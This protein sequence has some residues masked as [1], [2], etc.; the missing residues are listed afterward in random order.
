LLFRPSMFELVFRVLALTPAT[1]IDA[2]ARWFKR[3]QTRLKLASLTEVDSRGIAPAYYSDP[4]PGK[5]LQDVIR[6]AP[7]DQN[8]ESA[9]MKEWHHRYADIQ[10]LPQSI[11]RLLSAG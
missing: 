4:M 8:H 9:E 10:W 1:Y 3:R 11:S 7:K 2:M 5:Q 6:I